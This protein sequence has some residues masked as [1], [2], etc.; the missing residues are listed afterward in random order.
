MTVTIPPP[1]WV[2]ECDDLPGPEPWQQLPPWG[3]QLPPDPFPPDFL[4][5]ASTPQDLGPADVRRWA[6][7]LADER[8]FADLAGLSDEEASA[9]YVEL[10]TSLERLKSAA[11]AAQARVSERFD[12]AQRRLQEAEGVPAR[13]L[14][15]GVG[16]QVALARS[17]S[18]VKGG[19]FLGA[20]QAWVREMPRTL[21]ALADGRLNEWRA[22]LAVKE[23]ACLAVE[24]R[25]A[26]DEEFGR[27]LDKHPAMGDR[28]VVAAVRRLVVARD[29]EAFLRRAEK[30][31][32]DRRVTCRPAADGMTYVTALLPLREG[33]AV[34]AALGRAADA[35]RSAGDERSRGQLMA[36]TLVERL[37]GRP[38]EDPVDIHLDIVITD[39]GLFAEDEEAAEVVGTGPVPAAWVRQLLEQ[40]PDPQAQ[41]QVRRIFR[42]PGALLA[43]E[44]AGR[45]FTP[46]VQHLIRIRDQ[47][48]R[49]PWCDAPIRH[50]D[51]V[52]DHA[53]G[54]PTSLE[55]GQGLCERCNHT[56]RLPGWDAGVEPGPE[57]RVRLVTP[58]GHGYTSHPPTGPGR[59]VVYP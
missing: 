59:E 45:Y 44:T 37:T 11:S 31:V 29:A 21:E 1:D 52:V 12:L 27:L 30:A 22:T 5:A 7:L 40:V 50:G 25:Q 6:G 28:A 42:G 15:Q 34:Y 19:R 26:V 16:A 35:S 56:K 8:A 39:R 46:A 4:V 13:K 53:A 43:T 33:V 10:V 38:V 41:V 20:A 32:K 36:D 2:D 49:T 55:N 48:C 51:H 17:E 18:P 23:T 3:D 47:H 9:V 54:G 14:G 57:H 58:T 24:D